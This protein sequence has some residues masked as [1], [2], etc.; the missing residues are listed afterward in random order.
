MD[1][2]Y[3]IISQPDDFFLSDTIRRELEKRGKKCLFCSNIG[4]GWRDAKPYIYKSPICIAVVNNEFISRTQTRICVELNQGTKDTKRTYILTSE[5]NITL[6]MSWKRVEVID[7]CRGLNLSILDA[8]LAGAPAP[9]TE[10]VMSDA[11]E[12]D[13][14]ESWQ[15]QRHSC[16]TIADLMLADGQ[17][18]LSMTVQRALRYLTGDG[19]PQ[20][21]SRTASLL[22]KALEENPDDVVALYYMGACCESG[23]YSG[24]EAAEFYRKSAELGHT[25]SVIRLAFALAEENTEEAEKLLKQVREQGIY[26][27]SYGLGFIA[28]RAERFEDAVEYYSEAAEL[29]H[30]A[31]QN[32]LGCFYIEGKGVNDNDDAAFQW[33]ELAA[34]Q[35]LT[36]AMANLG[37]ILVSTPDSPDMERGVQLLRQASAE[38]NAEAAKFVDIYEQSVK[39]AKRQQLRKDRQRRAV[40]E[41]EDSGSGFLSSLVNDVDWK[42]L[43]NYA[44]DRLIRGN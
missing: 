22:M 1:Y 32:A 23:I 17:E 34:N 18:G 33:L 4:T 28:E 35:G 6:P 11:S 41:K 24:K 21:P 2:D 13:S 42:G 36:D 7:V 5:A 29:G 15:L 14:E 44:F 12:Q 8:I 19:V 26:E 27:A 38:G 20:D 16:P 3:T 39:E 40:A 37:A 25:P 31:A 43:G 10:S 9:Q 30:A